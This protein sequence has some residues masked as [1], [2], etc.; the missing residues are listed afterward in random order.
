[1]RAR[2]SLC[3]FISLKY[4][5]FLKVKKLYFVEFV[6][7]VSKMNDNKSIKSARKETEDPH[8]IHEVVYY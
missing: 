2:F 7:Y 6:T 3:F 1:M 8:S 5:R 4:N